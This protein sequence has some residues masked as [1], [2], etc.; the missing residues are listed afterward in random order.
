MPP[1]NRRQFL[2][3]GAAGTAAAALPGRTAAAAEGGISVRVG[4]ETGPGMPLVGYNTG[5]FMPGGNTTA[6]VEY[7][8]VNAV[9]FFASLSIWCPDDAFD[10]GDGIET[11]EDFDVRKEQLRRDSAAF[12]DW[13]RLR[14]VWST[15]VYETTNHY[16][17]DHQVAQLRRL[18]IT[19]IL[20]AA[21]LGWNSPWSG[22][23]LMWQKH[24]ALT[25]HLAERWDVERYNFVNEPDHPDAAGDIVDQA[26]YL[27]GLQIAADAIRAAIADVNAAHGKRLRAIVQAP[28]I[29][30]ASQNSGDFHMD[31]DPDAD[32]RDDEQGWGEL[33]LRNLRTDYHGRTVDQDLIDVFDTHLYNKTAETYAYE[34]AMIKAKAVEYT[35]TGVELP[36]LYSEFN[37]RNTGAFETSGDD[38]N[39]PM[40][41]SDLAE[42]WGAALTGGAAGMICFK[43]DNTV[44]AN[45]IRYGTGHYYVEDAGDY[46][47]RGVKKAAESNRMFA[48]RFAARPGRVVLTT[49]VTTDGPATQPGAIVCS[50]DRGPGRHSLWLPHRSTEPAHPV[51]I[52]LS[53]APG[54][55]GG[56][57]MIVREVSAEHSGD[58]IMVDQVPESGRLTLAQPA[59]CV[60]LAT[61]L[62]RRAAPTESAPIF[63]AGLTPDQVGEHPVVGRA[64]GGLGPAVGYLAFPVHDSGARAALLELDGAGTDGAPLTFFVYALSRTHW[65]GDA[66]TWDSAPYLD[67]EQVRADPVGRD[68][69]PAGQLTAPAESGVA[70]LDVTGVL[71]KARHGRLGFLLVRERRHADDT[72]DDGRRA[73]FSAARLRLWS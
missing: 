26:V 42:I 66:L 52:D 67:P 48:E 65:A 50:Y 64:G 51:T 63:A 3:V 12:I 25:H 14:R 27:R 33:C 35:P 58:V 34:L 40:I 62:E 60:W 19:P 73:E 53:A 69:F 10:P 6:W 24:Y 72:A 31:A 37:R 36:V 20:Q 11:V 5:H 4:P 45:G 8:A 22:L 17:L 9:R 16:N 30:H 71:G 39:T 43:F 13:S 54:R 61:V 46:A 44:R 38:L 1:F 49:T 23:F 57:T 32:H 18:G 55:P 56:G 28:M 7:S 68:V 15:H 41:F 21:E 47:I 29:T 2:A 59:D 70:R